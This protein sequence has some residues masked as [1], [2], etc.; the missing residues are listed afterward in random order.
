MHEGVEKQ[1][2]AL[3]SEWRRLTP[4]SLRIRVAAI[5]ERA[6][7]AVPLEETAVTAAR[8]RRSLRM[9]AVAVAAVVVVL[10]VVPG[11]R[12]TIARQAYRVLQTLRIAPATELTTFETKT[13][14]EVNASAREYQGQLDAGRRWG[15]H[16]AYGGLGGSV[17]SGSLP[18]VRRI[19]RAGVL[20]SLAT[21]QLLAPNGMYRGD[22][23]TFH[24][25]FLAPDGVVLTFFG[26]GDYEVFLVQAP[27]GRGQQISHSRSI[28]DSDGRVIGV[29]PLVERFAV[30]GQQVTWDPDTTGIMPNSSALRWEANGVS[31]SLY[32]RALT[33]YEA[34]AL[35]ST[36]RPLK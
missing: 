2:L 7:D 10:V 4:D 25:A 34:V 1:L 13:A 17:P 22:A 33:R 28:S 3:G 35:F 5:G 8:T 31:Y 15:V 24:H 32:G 9:A 27:V 19:D 12:A 30:E 20:T 18:E 29:A 36:L 11:S 21:I 14:D 16:T 26:F 23:V 6:R